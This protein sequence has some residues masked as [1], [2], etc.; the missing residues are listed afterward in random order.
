MFTWL[1]SRGGLLAALTAGALLAGC[2][3]GGDAPA[4]SGQPPVPVQL[5]EVKA[6]TIRSTL[7]YSGNVQSSQ[8][9]NLAPRTGGQVSAVFVDVGSVVKAGDRL[10][11]L[12][13]GT[14]PAQVAQAQANLQAAQARLDSVL[15]GSRAGDIAAAQSAYDTA[16]TRL[17]QLQNPLPTDQAAA[18]AAV[19][20]ARVAVDNATAGAATAKATL[21]GNVYIMCYQWGGFGI[22]CN[23]LV[24]PLPK[25]V[26]DSVASGLT[27]GIGQL[28]FTPGNNAIALLAA[29]AAYQTALNNQATAEQALIT[30]RLK[31]D[32]LLS[33]SAGD[34]A[35]ARTAVD[36]ARS[37]LDKAQV[38]FTDSDIRATRATV[39][40]AQAALST[41]QTLL[42][43]T[44]VVAPFDGVIAQRMAEVGAA[45]SPAAPLFVISAKAVE[46]RLTIEEA[47]IGLVRPDLATQLTVA[48]FPGKQFPGKV[49]SVAPTGDP[50][51]HTFEVKVFAQDPQ[52]LLLPGMFAEVTMVTADKAGVLI[53]P[54]SAIVTQGQTKAVVTVA[55]GRAAFRP[56]QTGVSDSTNVEVTSGLKAG[57]Q[58][59]IVGQN[60]V[61]EGGPVAVA[62]PGATT[63]T[64]TA[65]AKP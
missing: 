23:N 2:T 30:A 29:N 16:V 39:A 53:V 7:T 50:R 22:P 42:D 49:A 58:I 26:T 48:A 8:Q 60:S 34:L 14:L 37:T 17:H 1:T 63:P 11:T 6:G 4:A 43:Q 13:P 46:V 47:R 9:V 51:A 54:A 28:G 24:L 5:A 57:D 10:A 18:D 32:Q 44:T 19:T 25:E 45:A 52:A 15:A 40:Q 41:A 61:R 31:R 62:T 35:A 21:L 56:V 27:T 64:P 38:P 33:P 65:T 55:D 3:G 59:I 20:T 36:A 12:D